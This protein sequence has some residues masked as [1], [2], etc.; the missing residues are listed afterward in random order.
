MMNL[1]CPKLQG[2]WGWSLP[3]ALPGPACQEG[4]TKPDLL[5]SNRSRE[6]LG[7]HVI[8]QHGTWAGQRGYHLCSRENW[9][10]ILVYIKLQSLSPLS[11]THQC[12]RLA[13]GAEPQQIHGGFYTEHTFCA[14]SKG[15]MSPTQAPAPLSTEPEFFLRSFLFKSLAWPGL[16]LLSLR[17]VTR[18]LPEVWN[19]TGME[20]M[21][22][23]RA[24]S[25][26]A[27]TSPPGS[28]APASD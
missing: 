26:S 18:S 1:P 27:A 14:D 15:I 25:S 13:A 16:T 17:D 23:W 5:Y 10:E 24:S 19:D 28:P 20:V 3:A 11:L 21:I 7:T 6:L 22:F 4:K 2:T 8:T 12:M 9:E